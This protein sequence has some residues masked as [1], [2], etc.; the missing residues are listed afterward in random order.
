MIW[1]HQFIH[2]CA[3]CLILLL[4]LFSC[5]F[6][7]FCCRVGIT[8]VSI[9]I[10]CF[11]E[12]QILLISRVN[13]VNSTVFKGCDKVF[14]GGRGWLVSRVLVWWVTAMKFTAIYSTI[15]KQ[16]ILILFVA[17]VLLF[18]LGED[19]FHVLFAGPVLISP[20]MSLVFLNDVSFL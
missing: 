9:C 19:N 14:V 15:F 5:L 12:F 4:V 8:S 7:E 17:L 10:T 1:H 11:L 2:I 6:V 16:P 18:N 13:F 3:P 20:P